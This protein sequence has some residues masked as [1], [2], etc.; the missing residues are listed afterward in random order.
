LQRPRC[1]Y[2]RSEQFRCSKKGGDHCFAIESENKYHAIFNTE[3]CPCVHGSSAATALVA[4]GAR[5]ELTGP[6]KAREVAL[7]E[8]FITPEK[9]VQRENLLQPQELIAEIRV[10]PLGANARSVHLK[11]GEK[12]S[13]DWPIAETA[14]VLEQAGGRCTRAS[15]V[16]GAAAPVPWRA[17]TAEAALIGKTINEETARAA[18]R[19]AMQ[20]AT[21]L[22]QNAYKVPILETLVRRAILLA[23]AN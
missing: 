20:G 3:I 7:E 16:L 4:L 5:L 19:A 2:F 23:A 1:W 22:S 9:D 8:F 11:Q 13:F 17:R 6:K 21:P 12:E 14:V 10:P 15:I 18:A